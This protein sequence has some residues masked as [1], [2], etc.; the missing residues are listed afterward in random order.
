MLPKGLNVLD[1][2]LR[3]L[4]NAG[5]TLCPF[6][7]VSHY[8]QLD[9]RGAPASPQSWIGLFY[10]EWDQNQFGPL[11]IFLL[12]RFNLPIKKKRSL[13]RSLLTAFENDIAILKV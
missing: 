12:S 5:A 4:L 2:L 9:H 7:S 3:F 11:I 6:Q 8:L 13:G 1:Q 10:L